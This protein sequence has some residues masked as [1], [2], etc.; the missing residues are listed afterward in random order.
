MTTEVDSLAPF[1]S[2]PVICGEN[3]TGKDA[4]YKAVLALSRSIAG[5]TDLRSLVSGVAESLRSIFKFDHAGL[6]LQD[7]TR[8]AMEGYIW[9]EPFNPVLTSLRLPIDQDPAG[10]VWLNQQPLLISRLDFDTRWP[11]AA[12]TRGNLG[13]STL[14]LVPLTTGEH[15]LGA[16]GCQFG[17]ATRSEFGRDRVPSARCRRVRRGGGVLPREAGGTP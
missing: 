8:N 17:G 3:G 16:L 2:G 10:W 5:R 11:E 13:I 12:Q 9:N 4:I 6:I 15:R 1:A 7:P 14:V